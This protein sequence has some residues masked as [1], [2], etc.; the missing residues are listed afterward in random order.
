VR[1]AR[2]FIPIAFV[3]AAPA[4]SAATFVVTTTADSGPGSL[5]QAITDANG[6]PGSSVTFSIGTGTQRIRPL[7]ELPALNSGTIDGTT[8][9]GYSGSPLIEIDGSLL[10]SFTVGLSAGNGVV[11]ALVINHCARGLVLGDSGS[12]IGSFIGTDATGQFARPNGVGIAI[13]GPGVAIG[14]HLPTERN[15]IS[16]NNY[17]IV[18]SHNGA[19]IIGNFVGTNASGTGA[20]PNQDGISV[21]YVA[22]TVIAGNVLSGNTQY[23]IELFYANNSVVVGNQIGPSAFGQFF[24]STQRGGVSAYQSTVAQIGG[25][26]SGEPNVIA[27]NWDVGIGV[28][29]G[30]KRVRISRNAIHSNGFGIDLDFVPNPFPPGPRTTPNDPGDPDIGGN[31]L[32]NFPILEAVQSAGGSTRIRGNLNSE[33]SAPYRIEFFSNTACHESGYGEGATYLGSMDVVTDGGGDAA[34]DVT[35]PVMVQPS[36]AVTATATDQF[37]DTSEFSACQP[38]GL[39]F[40]TVEPC[41]LIDTRDPTGPD[42]SPALQPLARRDFALAGRCSIPATATS[43]SVNISVTEPT[44]PGHLT[45]HPSDAD[46][47]IASSINFAAGQTRSNNATLKLSANGSGSIAVENGSS[48]TV[49]FVLD[50]TGYFQ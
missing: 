5:R 18:V 43:L 17:G 6:S 48:G 36:A 22:N 26:I 19:T 42:G 41:R 21:Q 45:L 15:V 16:G 11:R 24:S 50:V 28:E 23:G 12:V 4:L 10:P 39:Y 44:S 31:L 47:P 9:P 33:P 40:Y 3:L 29:S 8:Q 20:L 35:F 30:A 34:F 7:T 38:V 25:L 2:G 37:G 46:P 49:H 14:G 32:Q 1:G 27:Y 13:L